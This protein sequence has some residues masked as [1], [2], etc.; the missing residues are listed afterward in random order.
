MMRRA[1]PFLLLCAT[2]SEASEAL[3]NAVHRDDLANATSLID[4][5]EN[6]TEPNR[7]GVTPLSMACLNG[8]PAMVKLLLEAKADP[9]ADLQGEETPLMTAAR[10]G[11]LECVRLLL[12]NGA[13]IDAIERRGQTALM[14]AASEGHAEVVKLLIESG[15][16]LKISLNSG[17][18]ALLFAIRAGHTQTVRI[19]L[20][21]GA[22]V[23]GAAKVR[24]ADGRSMRDHT[25]PLMLAI[26]N[27]H[28]ELALELVDRGAD[29]NDIRSGFAPLHAISWVRKT[30]SGDGPDGIP[31]PTI[32][33]KITSTQFVSELVKRGADVNIRQTAGGGGGPNLDLKGATPFLL[34]AATDDLPLLKALKQVGADP[35]L[36][37]S[38]GTTPLMAA[39]GVGIAAPGEDAGSEDEAV[40]TVEY[41]LSLGANINAVDKKGET[42]MHGAAY[43][44]VAKVIRLLDSHGADISIWNQKNKRGW[45]PLLIAQGYRFG[46]FRPIAETQEALME[47]MKERGAEFPPAPE[48][49][50]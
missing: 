16:D 13:E 45:T 49:K 28:L 9:N 44:G 39:A 23:S 3:I 6:A 38:V 14:W 29:P 27:G 47:I 4:S 31:P 46:N 50:K 40:E 43:K 21:A 22:D 37:N 48:R 7:Y 15:A 2:L 26:H 25:S 8:N 11:D 42:A 41:L 12:E 18:N 34:A 33:G 1:I 5:G 10:T 35:T 32:S 30:P 24:R 19:F 17:F 20:E 36:T